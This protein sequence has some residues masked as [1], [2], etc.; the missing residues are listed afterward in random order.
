MKTKIIALKQALN[1]NRENLSAEKLKTF[2]GLENLSDEEATETV[3]AIQTFASI[4]YEFM[5]QKN[6]NENNQLKKA[7]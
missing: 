2:K 5:N 4:I 7:A 6:E 3:F 1:P